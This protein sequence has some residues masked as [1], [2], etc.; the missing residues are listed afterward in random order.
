[1]RNESGKG[2]Q[3]KPFE[4]S[5]RNG[6]RVIHQIHGSLL[7]ILSLKHNGKQG[8]N[9]EHQ[10]CPEKLSWNRLRR[11]CN[12]FRPWFRPRRL[13]SAPE[14]LAACRAF[15][16][17]PVERLVRAH[18]LAAVGAGEGHEVVILRRCRWRHN[19]K[20]VPA[21]G[22][23]ERLAHEGFVGFKGLP[24]VRAGDGVRRHCL[25]SVVNRRW[26]LSIRFEQFG[27]RI[28]VI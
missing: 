6:I 23:I 27:V 28:S 26:F 11:G 17:L 10:R 25:K 4:P 3:R 13:C 8:Q 16:I 15:D 9:L 18:L 5:G 14:A 12:G 2:P 7:I 21:G 20:R 19:G 22:A 24:A 1:M